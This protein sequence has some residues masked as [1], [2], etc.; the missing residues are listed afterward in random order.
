MPSS[1][2]PS[3]FPRSTRRLP[4]ADT[5]PARHAV[6]EATIDT[7][8]RSSRQMLPPSYRARISLVIAPCL[9]LFGRLVLLDVSSLLVPSSLAC[10]QPLRRYSRSCG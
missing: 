4:S 8:R 1:I 6:N 9:S 7:A 10:A 3:T 5:V 2:A